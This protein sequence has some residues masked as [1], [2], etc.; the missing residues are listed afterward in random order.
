MVEAHVTVLCV[1]LVASKPAIVSLTGKLRGRS[2]YISRAPRRDRRTKIPSPDPK[3][4]YGSHVHLPDKVASF[5]MQQTQ[6]YS[7]GVSLSGCT[8]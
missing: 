5:E 3:G 6:R 7:R 8:E 4:G 2:K 1:C